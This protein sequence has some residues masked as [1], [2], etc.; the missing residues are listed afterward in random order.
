MNR[1]VLKKKFSLNLKNGE[2]AI[3]KRGLKLIITY[4]DSRAKK[5]NIIGKRP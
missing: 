1:K 3:I 2:S 4:S 5:T